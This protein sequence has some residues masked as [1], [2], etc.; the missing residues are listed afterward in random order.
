MSEEKE[1]VKITKDGL[2]DLLN[3]TLSYINEER[4]LALDRYRRQDEQI[5]SGQD[6]I[7]QGKNAVDF[8]KTASNRTD[9]ILIVA[10][11]IKD[12]LYSSDEGQTGS[13]LMT[14]DLKKELLN[15]M[16]LAK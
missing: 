9:E 10:K 16:R 6:F 2:E 11:M 14:D 15:M 3:K 13:G 7:L 4:E 8:L 1:K 12:I 5:Q